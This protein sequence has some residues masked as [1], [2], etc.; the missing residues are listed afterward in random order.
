MTTIK[1]K[2]ERV[3]IKSGN[4]ALTCKIPTD[5]SVLSMI[6]NRMGDGDDFRKD[7]W[8]Y[9]KGKRVRKWFGRLYDGS[10]SYTIWEPKYDN[11]PLLESKRWRAIQYYKKWATKYWDTAT[12]ALNKVG[13]AHAHITHVFKGDCS[14]W[15]LYKCEDCGD[16]MGPGVT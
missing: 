11:I 5:R 2:K 4:D 14:P 7:G 16:G 1:R 15:W 9:N 12:A 13:Q 3:A 6:H 8:V 10:C